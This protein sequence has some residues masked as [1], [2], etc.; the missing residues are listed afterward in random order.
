[1][2]SESRSFD[3]RVVLS[4]EQNS[5]CVY[6][7]QKCADA[8][9][10]QTS[11]TV[12]CMAACRRNVFAFGDAN[13]NV[14]IADT[15]SHVT[16][17]AVQQLK[18]HKGQVT[19]ID[20]KG[21]YLA[22]CGEQS[23]V[24]TDQHVRVFDVRSTARPLSTLR[25]SP[26]ASLLAFSHMMSSSLMVA[27]GSTGAFMLADAQLGAPQWASQVNAV[28]NGVVSLCLSATG[29]AFA[30]GDAG[31]VLHLWQSTAGGRASISGI[32][33]N[34]APMRPPGAVA[35]R[36]D[37]RVP[38]IAPTELL[39]APSLLSDV[40]LAHTCSTGLG[41]RQ[42]PRA[43]A[44][45]L[46]D[47]GFMAYAP[48]PVYNRSKPVGDAKR[49]VL[50]AM[51]RRTGDAQSK[52]SCRMHRAGTRQALPDAYLYHEVT[53]PA[54]VPKNLNKTPLVGLENSLPNCYANAVLQVMNFNKELQAGA[55]SHLCERDSCITCE[56][57]F[58]MHMLRSS[59]NGGSCQPQNLLR[60]L[61]QVREASAL[62]LLEGNNQLEARLDVALSRLVT[63]FQRFLLEQLHREQFRSPTKSWKTIS[64]RA[65]GTSAWQITECMTCSHCIERTHTTFQIDLDYSTGKDETGKREQRSTHESGADQPSFA[66]LLQRSIAH[67]TE[68][69]AWCN[70]ERK[71]TRMNQFRMLTSPPS[72]LI[73]NCAVPTTPD[74]RFWG[75][76]P[77]ASPDDGEKYYGS[78]W[79]PFCLRVSLDTQGRSADVTE[80]N[81]PDELTSSSSKGQNSATYVLASLVCI[82]R[83]R[84]SDL[85]CNEAVGS[86]WEPDSRHGQMRH[87]VAH[88]N[89]DSAYLR[90]QRGSKEESPS[91]SRASESSS[92]ESEDGNGNE[93]GAGWYLMNDAKIRR[94]S[95]TEVTRLYGINKVPVL[96]YYRCIDNVSTD[97]ETLDED[98]DERPDARVVDQSQFLRLS[99]PRVQHPK[100]QPLDA[101][102]LSKMRL[103]GLDAEFVAL[104][105]PEVEVTQE[106]FE[107]S[108]RPS[109][110]GLGR[111]SVVRGEGIWRGSACIDD[112]VNAVEPVYDHLP[113]FS[114]LLPGDLEPARTKK[115]LVT[116]K[117]AYLKLRF[118]VDAGFIFIGHGL[119]KDF[120][121]INITVPDEQVIDTVELFRLPHSRRLSLRFLAAFFLGIDVQAMTHDSIEDA[122]VAV[123]LY[124]V[125]R[126][127]SERNRIND[128]LQEMYR[129]GRSRGWSITSD[130]LQLGQ[131]NCQEHQYLLR[132]SQNENPV[133]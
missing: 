34:E 110:L 127:L 129:A 119:A 112:Y 118:L 16:A 63:G 36:E 4:F 104:T 121:M 76:Q 79:L 66:T 99:C 24:L 82:V 9:T 70:A 61:R 86:L 29:S 77:S 87:V 28:G 52:S 80:A 35:Q 6:D 71:Y 13:G 122:H 2:Q 32:V 23:A 12:T 39:Q 73:V 44:Q 93:D 100:L 54:Q 125:Y 42:L 116:L 15:R 103:L 69:R 78:A 133:R 22:T 107:R 120:R 37:A 31:G 106:G 98:A 89:V 48:N 128:T 19:C 83:D 97:E 18:A 50:S 56:M 130:L 91:S 114:G 81:S 33:A 102:E 17:A 60:A 90:R 124:V 40:D 10:L 105:P 64:E 53:D 49:K 21:D 45:S 126:S 67:S 96:A 108:L 132:G 30:F 43:I 101:N 72:N 55:Q 1:M 109:R 117:E 74:L 131:T 26:G 7:V 85:D 68:L 115:N 38:E 123:Q 51:N 20:G 25:F 62:G 111:V 92:D 47:A 95:D 57:N 94:T 113:K 8:H 41:A 3:G 5:L 27:S 88:V 14:N 84:V 75:V 65:F 59:T 46:G 11:S 58:L